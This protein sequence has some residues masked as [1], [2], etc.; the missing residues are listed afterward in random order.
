MTDEEITAWL[1]DFNIK[2]A[3]KQSFKKEELKE[4]FDM[5][6]LLTMQNKPVT[7]CSSCVASVLSTLKAECRRRNIR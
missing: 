5:Y 2:Y 7:T 6:N 4:I 1:V 3:F